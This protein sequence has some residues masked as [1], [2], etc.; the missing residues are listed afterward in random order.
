MQLE[1]KQA[2]AA[3]MSRIHAGSQNT[4]GTIHVGDTTS[5]KM[6]RN[7]LQV[8]NSRKTS[9]GA[10]MTKGLRSALLQVLL[11]GTCL[12]LYIRHVGL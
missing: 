2:F 11:L 3:R 7:V 10:M 8:R 6:P 12:T 5:A 4:C 9:V 1:Q